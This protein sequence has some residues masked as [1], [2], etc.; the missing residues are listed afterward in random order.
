MYPVNAP[1]KWGQSSTQHGFGVFVKTEVPLEDY[2]RTLFPLAT[3]QILIQNHADEILKYIYEKVL[4]QQEKD[5]SF[6]PQLHCY[7]SKTGFHL[8]RTVK[9]DPVAELFIYDLVY[10]NRKT[11]R[12]DFGEDRKSFGYRFEDGKPIPQTMIS[13]LERFPSLSKTVYTYC[14]YLDDKTELSNLVK[15]FLKTSKNTTENQLFWLAKI[16]EDYLMNPHNY[17]EIIYMLYNHT[18][19]T[20]L[21]KAKIFEIP[22]HRFG[23]PELRSEYL[24]AGTSDWL[25][26]SAAVG[27]RKEIKIHRNYIL[28]YF[29]KASPM[30]KLISD[31]ISNLDNTL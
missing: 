30:N 14:R 20:S 11:F 17:A 16:T 9:L 25:S 26:W 1:A 31:C 28:E 15:D 23:L 3:T 27:C 5:Y 2:P 6:L 29:S 8:R 10:K 22:E 21:T 12:P 13:F 4:N 7:A 19:A 24:R 18:N